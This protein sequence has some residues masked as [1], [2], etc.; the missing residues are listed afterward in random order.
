MRGVHVQHGGVAH[1]DLPWVLHKDLG[2]EA[3]GLERQV[4]AVCI[5]D[6]VAPPHGQVGGGLKADTHCVPGIGLLHLLVE[7]MHAAHV[8]G[9]MAGH[10]RDAHAGAQGSGLNAAAW[11]H[12]RAFDVEDVHYGDA[13]RLAHQPAW[14]VHLIKSRHQGGAVVPGHALGGVT[15]AVPGPGRHRHK[16]DL[17][18]VEAQLLEEGGDLGPDL[19]IPALVK[20]C[21]VHL[22]DHD[23]EL[24]HPQ[25]V[26]QLG[27]FPGLPI[28]RDAPLKCPVGGIYHQQQGICAESA[29][30]HVLD[31]ILVTRDIGYSDQVLG[32]L[33]LAQMLVD[34]DTPL[35]LR[36]TFIKCPGILI[37]SLV[38]C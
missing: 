14:H 29:C 33:N 15:Q 1:H 18:G 25:A 24:A 19:V 21:R 34:C 3:S 36:L 8:Q 4:C 32:R 10:Y 9:S 37:R 35:P 22:V 28:L 11:N 13:Q 6:D 2:G 30:Y 26:R 38:D 31:I 12:A 23:D 20:L 16:G 7:E 17:L 27:V 5:T